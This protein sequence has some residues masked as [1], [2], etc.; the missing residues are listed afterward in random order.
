ML[1]C[2]PKDATFIIHR[3]HYSTESNKVRH[4]LTRFLHASVTN[5]SCYSSFESRVYIYFCI[6]Y[7]YATAVDAD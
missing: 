4:A 6:C 1:L 2:V 5:V 3:Q 7:L